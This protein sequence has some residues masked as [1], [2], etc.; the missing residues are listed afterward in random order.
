MVSGVR[1]RPELSNKK[2]SGFYFYGAQAT[3]QKSRIQ[4]EKSPSEGL[5]HKTFVCLFVNE[6]SS[7][8]FFFLDERHCWPQRS[9]AKPGRGDGPAWAFPGPEFSEARLLEFKDGDNHKHGF[10]FHAN[11]LRQKKRFLL[12]KFTTWIHRHRHDD[13]APSWSLINW[14]FF[15]V[16]PAFLQTNLCKVS[17]MDSFQ[18]TAEAKRSNVGV[19]DGNQASE[20]CWPLNPHSSQT[21]WICWSRLVSSHQLRGFRWADAL[22]LA[23]GFL[24]FLSRTRTK[25]VSSC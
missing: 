13:S 9:L 7:S 21:C 8:W 18:D 17:L 15:P 23:D 2:K 14:I 11:L 3:I 16:I 25:L 6:I 1:K 20:A 24:R 12:C 5:G 19:S 22:V 10:V 4:K